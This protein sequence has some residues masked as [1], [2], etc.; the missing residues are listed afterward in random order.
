M[1]AKND[2]KSIE[3]SQIHPPKD[4]ATANGGDV[5]RKNLNDELTWDSNGWKIKVLDLPD[6]NAAPPTEVS[7]DRYIL[8]EVASSVVDSG[9]DG[10]AIN[11]IVEFS[12]TSGVWGKYTPESGDTA[13]DETSGDYYQ[14]DGT[15]WSVL[16]GDNGIIGGGS[17]RFDYKAKTTSQAAPPGDKFIKWDQASQTTAANL[18]VSTVNDEGGAEIGDI[19]R[20]FVVAGTKFLIFARTNIGQ[21]QIWTIDSI[22]DN[23]T[24]F[25]YTVT[26]ISS[27]G[28]DFT[29]GQKLSAG[30]F[31]AGAVGGGDFQNG[32]EAGLAARTLGNTDSFG[33][34]FKTN[35]IVRVNIQDDGKVGIGNTTNA[36][37]ELLHLFDNSDSESPLL[38]IEQTHTDGHAKI[39]LKSTGTGKVVDYYIDLST[40]DEDIK[41]VTADGP[42]W[43]FNSNTDLWTI[44]PDI[45]TQNSITVGSDLTVLST[46]LL[47][48]PH[49]A[50]PSLTANGE[51][52]IRDTLTDFSHGILEYFSGEDMYVISVPVAQ[53]TSPSNG[54]LLVYNSTADEW[55]LQSES[56]IFIGLVE[57]S[58]GMIEA[59]SNKT[60]ILDQ[61][62][63]YAYDIDT[64][65]AKMV[66]GTLS[67]AIQI[68]GTPVTGINTLAVSSVEATG[69]ASALN[70]VAI[71]QTVTMVVTAISTPVDYSFTLKTT[72]T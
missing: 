47:T 33:L 70:A 17:F 72:R 13:Y 56:S 29:D 7:G 35:N 66:S 71:G 36:V 39:R 43:S 14:F 26:L 23:T 18:F 15:T 67:V 55:Q 64:L 1:G 49:E 40:T 6:I 31:G 68:D 25:T 62:A 42:W 20:Q 63:A 48:I 19:L 44:T 3:N 45:I 38:L 69:T 12:G 21:R 41:A 8:I 30:W 58:G 11:D 10:A 34:G 52:A 46:A 28:V 53:L 16:V 60:Y 32:G 9:W 51:L 27:E 2:H 4:F 5:V 57:S 54:D 61:S 50:A 65:I 24:Y 22:V 37:D 59:P